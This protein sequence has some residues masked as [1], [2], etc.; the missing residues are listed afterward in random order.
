MSEAGSQLT[1]IK[2]LFFLFS[3]GRLAFYVMVLS[4]A[5]VLWS[6]LLIPSPDF[7]AN[8]YATAGTGAVTDEENPQK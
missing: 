4:S 3:P 5:E 8:N 7:V 1:L 6:S 2:T